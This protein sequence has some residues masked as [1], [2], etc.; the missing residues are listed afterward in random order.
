MGSSHTVTGLPE[1]N[2]HTV[3]MQLFH[4]DLR[5]AKG[6]RPDNGR[7]FSIPAEAVFQLYE[8]GGRTGKYPASPTIGLSDDCGLSGLCRLRRTVYHCL[9]EF[10]LG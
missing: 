3:G 9:E 8:F 2:Y 6:F 5:C 1:Y 10:R 4:P 7:R